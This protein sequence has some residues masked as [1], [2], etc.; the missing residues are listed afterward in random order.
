MQ[1]ISVAIN[2]TLDEPNVD[3]M[4]LFMLGGDVTIT[5]GSPVSRQFA[6]Y[7]NTERNGGA[8]LAGV[9]D[10]GNEWVWTVNKA[11]VKP[12]G[13]FTYDDQDWSQFNFIV[14]VLSDSDTPSQPFGVID[15]YGVDEDIDV[16]LPLPDNA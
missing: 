16:S 3:N 5:A 4:N 1:E 7:T 8:R 12:D 14:E 2:L 6:P 13:D 10:T 11:T 15:H 9:S